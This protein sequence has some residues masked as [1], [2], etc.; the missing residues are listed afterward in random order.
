MT[1]RTDA[2]KLE[3]D[4]AAGLLLRTTNLARELEREN[5]KLREDAERL[6]WLAKHYA[7]VMVT[8]KHGLEQMADP[9]GNG[10]LRAAID[11]ARAALGDTK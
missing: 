5:A 7:Y 6:Q 9:T 3:A 8:G 11:K 1:P 2:I 4:G 10:N